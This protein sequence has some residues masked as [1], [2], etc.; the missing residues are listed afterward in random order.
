MFL[1]TVVLQHPNSLIKAGVRNA[2][3]QHQRVSKLKGGVGGTLRDQLRS[4]TSVS[5]LSLVA[6]HSKIQIV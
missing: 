5:K 1:L 2:E 4:F 3:I 6:K